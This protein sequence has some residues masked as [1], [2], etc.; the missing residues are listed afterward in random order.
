M[1][2]E[3]IKPLPFFEW[4]IPIFFFWNLPLA[5]G[6]ILIIWRGGSIKKSQMVLTVLIQ[7]IEPITKLRQSNKL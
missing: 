2:N 4:K 7:I 1:E 6:C 3:P 5:V